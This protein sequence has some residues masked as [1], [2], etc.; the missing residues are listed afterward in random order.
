MS[1]ERTSDDVEVRA[2]L[3]FA[4]IPEWVL[5]SSIS[6]KAIRLYCVLRRKADNNT[7]R[8]HHSRKSLAALMGYK[9]PKSVDRVVKELEEIGALTVRRRKSDA[10][11][12]L[13]NLY[14]VRSTPPGGVGAEMPLPSPGDAPTVGAGNGDELRAPSQVEEPPNPPAELGGRRIRRCIDGSPDR[15]CEHRRGKRKCTDHPKHDRDCSTCHQRPDPPP[16]AW[17]GDCDP[18][19][20]IGPEHRVL[21][22]DGK[23]IPCPKCH[24]AALRKA[25]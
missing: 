19:G 12:W 18:L 22:V 13:T 11:D 1:T 8:S 4:Q 10:G 6:D 5:F 15:Q 25:S 23:K 16:P 7:G 2:D 14:I 24:P 3:Y 9:D 21:Y 17:C 20:R